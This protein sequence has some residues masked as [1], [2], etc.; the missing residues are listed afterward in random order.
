MPYVY[1]VIAIITEVLGTV[2]LPLCNGFTR[3]VPSLFVLIFYGLS[4]YFLS[5]TLKYMNIAFA[6][7]I[8]SAFGIILIGIIGY[9]FFKQKLD[10][11]FVLGT[12]FILIGT[13]II[14]AYSKTIMH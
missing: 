9:L 2:S 12:L 8:W 13:I 14:C 6:Y 4:F 7:S 10:L 11:P 5:L 3:L 1:L